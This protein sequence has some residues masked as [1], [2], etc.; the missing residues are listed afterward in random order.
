MNHTLDIHFRRFATGGVWHRVPF[1]VSLDRLDVVMAVANRHFSANPERDL[2]G[3]KMPK[4]P[5]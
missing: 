1:D 5:G 4:E 2:G 3:P